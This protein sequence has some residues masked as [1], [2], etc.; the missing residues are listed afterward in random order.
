MTNFRTRTR[1]WLVLCSALLVAKAADTPDYAAIGK[2]FVTQ[3]A[4]GQFEKAAKQFDKTMAEN[5]PPEKLKAVWN[6]LVAQAGDF[7]S[8]DGTRTEQFG[9]YRIVYV[10]CVFQKGSLDA[11]IAFN[12]SG[13]IAGLYF[14]PTAK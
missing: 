10:T 3:L 4:Q 7:K 12:D 9:G 5:L 1:C 13:Q 6:S 11:K 14:V 2:P 8:I